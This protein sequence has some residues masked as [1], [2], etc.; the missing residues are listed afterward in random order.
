MV[1]AAITDAQMTPVKRSSGALSFVVGALTGLAGARVLGRR[2]SPREALDPFGPDVGSGTTQ[3]P[4]DARSLANGFEEG[5]ADARQLGWTMAIFATAAVTAVTLMVLLV[6]NW[7]QQ[8][9]R[10]ETG[11]T[12]LQ[13]RQSPPPSPQL[14]ANPIGELGALKA[15]EAAKLQGYARLNA[16]TARIPIDRAM[17]LVTGQSL[18]AHAAPEHRP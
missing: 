11:L 16:N 15:R 10:L 12:S 18:D 5:D 7:H 2:R 8:D 9:A 6:S 13:R 4:V 14:Q 1:L 17:A 3:G